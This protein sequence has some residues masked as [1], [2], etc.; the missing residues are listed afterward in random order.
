MSLRGPQIKLGAETFHRVACEDQLARAKT[1]RKVAQHPYKLH[2]RRGR[3]IRVDTSLSRRM[4]P[5][6]SYCARPR[7]FSGAWGR[8]PLEGDRPLSL[9][10]VYIVRLPMVVIENL[11]RSL[12][13]PPSITGTDH[14]AVG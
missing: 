1:V 11:E 13:S 12:P 8:V 14:H 2:V 3:G 9:L 10:G 5:L 7:P 6:P 4:D